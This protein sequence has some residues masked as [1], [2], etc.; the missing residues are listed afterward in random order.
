MELTGDQLSWLLSGLDYIKQVLSPEVT[1][2]N[3]Y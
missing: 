3:F 2:T 1:A